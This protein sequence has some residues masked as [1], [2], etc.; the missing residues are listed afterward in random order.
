MSDASVLS[1]MYQCLRILLG[2]A[3]ETNV[4]TVF[5]VWRVLARGV[6][7]VRELGAK[8]MCLG[9][10]FLYLST[11]LTFQYCKISLFWHLV[12]P[13]LICHVLGL[14]SEVR[15]QWVSGELLLLLPNSEEVFTDNYQNLENWVGHLFS[16]LLVLLF[17]FYFENTCLTLCIF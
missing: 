13:K 15:K 11:T 12:G 8:R 3:R 10:D 5:C 6:A 16:P 9:W 4:R 7:A 1:R 2:I 17:C 14:W